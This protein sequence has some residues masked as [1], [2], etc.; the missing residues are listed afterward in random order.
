[1]TFWDGKSVRVVGEAKRPCPVPGPHPE[2]VDCP[3]CAAGFPR[4]PG[5]VVVRQVESDGTVKYV[6]ISGSLYA[7]LCELA[8]AEAGTK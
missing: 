2:P 4:V 8:E 1:M 5:P 7:E 3:M 6:Q